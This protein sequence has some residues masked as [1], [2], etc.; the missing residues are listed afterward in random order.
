M[1]KFRNK[2]LQDAFDAGNAAA[3]AA[4]ALD[5][6]APIGTQVGARANEILLKDGLQVQVSLLSSFEEMDS[7]DGMRDGMQNSR[8]TSAAR[9]MTW[10]WRS[11]VQTA[12]TADEFFLSVT[13][14][15]TSTD[16]VYRTSAGYV[17]ILHGVEYLPV[18][19]QQVEGLQYKDGGNF[20]QWLESL[21]FEELPA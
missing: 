16:G 8:M 2:S 13:S 21:D 4:A 3:F 12:P 5:F 1:P 11:L 14:G 18:Q 19:L 7:G 15:K 6:C 10:S 17:V 9:T 20:I